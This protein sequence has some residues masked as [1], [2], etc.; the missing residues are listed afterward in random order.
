V[1]NIGR[2]R[3]L[4]ALPTGSGRPLGTLVLIHAFPLHAG[5]WEPQLALSQ[6]GWR[7]VVPHLKGL[8][9]GAGE[10]ATSMDDF[11]GEV[12]DLLDSLHIE[13]AVI[14][15][16]SLGGYV[17]FALLRHAPAYARGLILADTRPQADAPAAIEARKRML[18]LVAA[19][20]PEAVAAEMLP[21][22]LGETTRRERPEVVARVDSMIRENTS[23][24]IAGAITAMMNRPDSTPL[25]DTIRV[26]TLVIVG[27]EDTL[28]PPSMSED[29]ARA[30]PGAQLTILEG[31]GHLANLERP[32]AF[33]EAVAT[34]LTRRL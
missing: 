30:I 17:L 8:G 32:D 7:V 11:A 24:G 3:Y 9:P 10:P 34:F 23:K 28:T 12:I 27:R 20:G 13:D 4:E 15:G 2:L 31:A 1:P 29:M 26:P 19:N 21:K 33:S 25:L 14:G 16:L 22:L 18:E 5:L 6:Q